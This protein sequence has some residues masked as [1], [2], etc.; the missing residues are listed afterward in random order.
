MKAKIL[1]TAFGLLGILGFSSAQGTAD[2]QSAFDQGNYSEVY[3]QA[4]ALATADG[5]ALAARA[6]TN[7]ALYKAANM[8]EQTK[9]FD[10]G[11]RQSPRG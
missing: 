7:Y 8:D 11:R 6:G 9:W 10:R 3:D 1:A 2:L 4:M 5:Y